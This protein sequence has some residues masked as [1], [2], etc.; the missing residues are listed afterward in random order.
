M[1]TEQVLG[2]LVILKTDPVNGLLLGQVF[3]QG[4]R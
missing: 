1:L 3:F 2:Y 4:F